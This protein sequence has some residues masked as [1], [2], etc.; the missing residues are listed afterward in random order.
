[1]TEIWRGKEEIWESY[2][3]CVWQAM[4]SEKHSGKNRSGFP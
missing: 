4:I 1:M 3:D 2:V